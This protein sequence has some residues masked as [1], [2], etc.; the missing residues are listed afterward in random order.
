MALAADVFIA[1]PD[2]RISIL[3]T[4]LLV[5]PYTLTQT[6]QI[7]SK[8]CLQTG[9]AIRFLCVLEETG[10]AKAEP[11]IPGGDKVIRHP[12]VKWSDA[13]D[14]RAG[15]GD[16]VRSWRRGL[17]RRAALYEGNPVVAVDYQVGQ[18][19]RP[20]M[21]DGQNAPGAPPIIQDRHGKSAGARHAATVGSAG[22]A[23][24][25]PSRSTSGVTRPNNIRFGPGIGGAS[26]LI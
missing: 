23:W 18:D 1:A 20:V 6:D 25:D 14:N 2:A 4:G 9:R 8:S 3:A 10:G 19:R 22:G 16:V 11:L 7:T 13:A 24:P 12:Q 26:P 21:A 17:M 15:Q 5:R